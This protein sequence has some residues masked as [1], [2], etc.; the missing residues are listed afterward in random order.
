MTAAEFVK[1]YCEVAGWTEKE[2]YESQVPMP[3]STSPSGWAAVSNSPLA[4]KAHVDLYMRMPLAGMDIDPVAYMYRDNLHSDARFSLASKIGNWSPEDINE[5]EIREIPLYATPP[6]PVAV[7]D[8][9]FDEAWEQHLAGVMCGDNNKQAAISFLNACRA[10]MLKA[11][12]VTAATVPEGWKLVP[13][14]LTPEME[15]AWDAAP[16]GCQAE[17]DAMLNVAPSPAKDGE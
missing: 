1:Q 17:W 4:I 14:K 16:N 15:Q 11:G 2:F 8:D 3:D 7:P 9:V 10:A 13:K 6:S 5:Y 12:P